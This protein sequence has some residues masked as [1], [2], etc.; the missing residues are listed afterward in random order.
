MAPVSTFSILFLTIGAGRRNHADPRPGLS[1]QPQQIVVEEVRPF[2]QETA[3][4]QGD[5]VPLSQGD[6]GH[7]KDFPTAACGESGMICI[8][9][10]RLPSGSTIQAWRL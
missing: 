9:S 4:T 10:I 2:L 7:R 3:T 8:S 6:V 5:N 1:G